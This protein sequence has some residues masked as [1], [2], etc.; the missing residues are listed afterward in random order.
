MKKKKLIQLFVKY[1]SVC[2]GISEIIHGLLEGG[3]LIVLKLNLLFLSFYDAL[4]KFFSH[5]HFEA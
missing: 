2:T 1:L 3:G 4:F 5:A